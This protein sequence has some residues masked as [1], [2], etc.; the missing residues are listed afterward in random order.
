MNGEYFHLYFFHEK[1]IHFTLLHETKSFI[2]AN[3]HKFIIVDL[4]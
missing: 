4:E 1:M 2:T 3:L